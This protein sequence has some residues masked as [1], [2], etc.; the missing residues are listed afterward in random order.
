VRVVAELSAETD[1]LV[2]LHYANPKGSP[3]YC[4]NS[5]LARARVE[6]SM[7]GGEKIVASSRAAA[8]EI[9]TRDARHGVRMYL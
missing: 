5:K 7:P 2:G 8:L 6:L 3:T 1:D 9:G 4:L